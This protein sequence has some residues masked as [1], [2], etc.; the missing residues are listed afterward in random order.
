VLSI[1]RAISCPAQSRNR[2]RAHLL[3]GRL[4]KGQAFRLFE[5]Y[6]YH[7]SFFTQDLY[8]R[9]GRRRWAKNPIRA[10]FGHLLGSTKAQNSVWKGQV[11]GDL[12]LDSPRRAS[13]RAAN[14]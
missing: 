13:T 7:L 2:F 6:L 1:D 8:E 14:E 9:T 3:V 5:R 11:F 4:K 12:M 10:G